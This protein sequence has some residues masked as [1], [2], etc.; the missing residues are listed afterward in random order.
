MNSILIDHTHKLF[1]AAI[2]TARRTN[3][4]TVP[5]PKNNFKNNKEVKNYL[6][7]L[8][9]FISNPELFYL[10][11]NKI[12]NIKLQNRLSLPRNVFNSLD[13]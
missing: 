12:Y 7:N 9:N 1:K 8:T 5:Y 13:N 6:D 3:L 10:N 11:K 2:L 4:K